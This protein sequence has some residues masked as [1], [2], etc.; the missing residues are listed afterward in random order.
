MNQPQPRPPQAT[1]AGVLI[2][3]GSI[4]LILAAWQ[5]I[6]TLHTLEVQQGLEQWLSTN[7]LDGVTV[8]GMVATL[9]VLCLLGAGAAAAAAILGFQV[10]QRSASARIALAVL[11]PLLF[12]GAFATDMFLAAMAVFGIG[13]LW[14]QPTRDWYAGRP[15]VQRY[16][17]QRKARLERMRSG[18]PTLPPAPGQQGQPGQPQQPVPPAGQAP[19][20]PPM[21]PVPGFRLPAQRPAVVRRPGALVAACIL[22]WTLSSIAAVGL[23]LVAVVVA[24]RRDEIFADLKE[25]QPDLVASGDLTADTMVVYFVFVAVGLVL[26]ALFAIVLAAVAFLGQNWARVTLAVSGVCA[27]LLSLVMAVNGP[28]LLVVTL[29]IAMATWLLLRPD[30]SDWYRVRR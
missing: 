15:W 23:A 11:A 30:V 18:S 3:G 12:V 9:R 13:L 10:F 5:R 7:N 20:L 4:V 16:E 17:A 25:Q 22:T 27:G 8:D 19:P 1:L 29:S 28:P 26:W 6:S 14:A 2:I 24:A 21:A